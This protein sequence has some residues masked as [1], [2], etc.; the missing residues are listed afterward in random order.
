MRL[1][2]AVVMALC[3]GGSAQAGDTPQQSGADDFLRVFYAEVWGVAH[4]DSLAMVI[5]HGRMR[6][7]ELVTVDGNSVQGEAL[8]LADTYFIE[9][10]SGVFGAFDLPDESHT[11]SITGGEIVTH[12]GELVPVLAM[13]RRVDLDGYTL[14]TFT[15][16]AFRDGGLDA[17]AMAEAI[18]SGIRQRGDGTTGIDCV[19]HHFPDGESDEGMKLCAYHDGDPGGDL[20]CCLCYARG[21]RCKLCETPSTMDMNILCGGA[22][23]GVGA[24][25]AG[26]CSVSTFG[27]GGPA[28]LQACLLG[29]LVVYDACVGWRLDEIADDYD[30]CN[31]ARADCLAFNECP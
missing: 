18:A 14:T 30:D 25:C 1:G 3:L 2:C 19:A 4:D 6:S 10:G 5:D 16:V 7:L 21:I 8:R 15:P 20:A 12:L 28:C 31:R 24:T 9:R 22:G 27:F 17:G 29:G 26:I 13:T 11:F 23:I